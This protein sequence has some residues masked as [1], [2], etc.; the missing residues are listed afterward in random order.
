M[1]AA[2]EEQR[3]GVEDAGEE[4]AEHDAAPLPTQMQLLSTWEVRKV[5][6]NC[7]TRSEAHRGSGSGP[8]Y[9]IDTIRRYQ[10]VC[11]VLTSQL[12]SAS[13]PPPPS[14]LCTLTVTRLQVRQSLE[15][16]LPS[17]VVAVSMKTPHRFLRSN[18]IPVPATGTLDIPLQLT[19]SLQV[20]RGHTT[21]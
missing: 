21:Q 1:S 16:S 13:P 19:F 8:P 3:E 10:V 7:V 12:R 11:R 4:S 6:H 2:M 20:L 14:R 9:T 17:L 5:P 15:P 18:E